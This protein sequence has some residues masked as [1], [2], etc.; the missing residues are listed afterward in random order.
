MGHNIFGDSVFVVNGPYAHYEMILITAIAVVL[1][2]YISREI[3]YGWTFAQIAHMGK[4][5]IPIFIQNN[6]T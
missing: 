1:I 4:H 6:Y 2:K 5:V 3:V